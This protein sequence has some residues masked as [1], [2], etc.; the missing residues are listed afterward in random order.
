MNILPALKLMK[1]LEGKMAAL[2]AWYSDEFKSEPAAASVFEE[3]SSEEISL[4]DIIQ[5]RIRVLQEKSKTLSA[6]EMDATSIVEALDRIESIQ[7]SPP[8][9][10]EEAIRSALDLE[11]SAAESQ[12]RC[13]FEESCAPVSGLVRS[14]GEGSIKHIHGLVDFA[15]DLGI[16]LS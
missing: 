5:S 14:L 15:S 3:L 13:A 4:L 1:E 12:Y 11:K 7:N 9:N 16:S 10:V 6:C 2:Y 8:R